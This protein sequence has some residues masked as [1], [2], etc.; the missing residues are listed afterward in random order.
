M[1]RS[2]V[3]LVCLL[4]GSMPVV[5]GNEIPHASPESVGVSSERLNKI[6]EVVQEHMDDGRLQGAVIAVARRGKVVY[7]EAQGE[8][9]GAPLKNDAMFNMASSTKPILGVAAMIMIEEGKFKPSDPVERY[10]PEFKGIKVVD[11]FDKEKN[12]WNLVD[13]HRPVTIH[14]LLTHTSGFTV[15]PQAKGKKNWKQDSKQKKSK[16]KKSKQK[17]QADKKKS[18]ENVKKQYANETLASFVENHMAKGPLAFQPGEKWG[19]GSSLEAVA[20]VIEVVSGM[21]FNEFVQTRIFDPLDMKDTHWIVPKDKL[22]RMMRFVKGKAGTP[23]RYFS[24]SAGLVST[25]RDYLH[26]EQMLANKGELFGQ[27]ILKP[28]T[29]AMMSSDQIDG[30]FGSASKGGRGMV[31]G[32]TVSVTVDPEKANNGRSVGAFGW[33][34]AGGTVSWT[35]PK[36]E[37]TGVIMVQQPTGTLPRAVAKAIMAALTD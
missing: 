22:P 10:I 35:D 8:A 4:A 28:E 23:T 5:K 18:D 16:K 37:M 24:G 2:I 36:E 1:T 3:F 34:G 13:V 12:T 30:L 29:V 20:R 6:R 25:A 31:F 26:F 11:T 19:Y 7:F 21:P 33:G 17:R 15:L 14:D 27:R 9:N 32:Y